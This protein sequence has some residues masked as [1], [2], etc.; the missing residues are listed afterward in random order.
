MMKD[1]VSSPLMGLLRSHIMDTRMHNRAI[2]GQSCLLTSFETL[3][4][5]LKLINYPHWRTL[6]TDKQL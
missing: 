6:E 4:Q 3:S 1:K 5:V 2:K